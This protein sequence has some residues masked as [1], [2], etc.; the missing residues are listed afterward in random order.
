MK[1]SDK[2]RNTRVMKYNTLNNGK[3]YKPKREK[4]KEYNRIDIKKNTAYETTEYYAG[5]LE[6]II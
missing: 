4:S 1:P 6:N 5:N 2:K 3:H